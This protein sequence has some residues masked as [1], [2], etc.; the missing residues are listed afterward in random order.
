M[1]VLLLLLP[2]LGALAIYAW[3]GG[4]ARLFRGLGMAANVAALA[5]LYVLSRQWAPGAPVEFTAPWMPQLGLEFAIWLD[6]SALFWAW[7][8]LGIGLLVNWYAGHY[9]DPADAPRRFYGAMMLFMGSM[10]GVVLS[11]NLVLMFVFWEMTS[12]TSFLLIGHWSHKPGAAAGAKRALLLTGIGGLVLMTGVALLAIIFAQPGIEGPLNWDVLW[13]A[14]EQVLAHPLAR[15]AMIL[16]LTGAFTK[17]AQFPF[18][19]W[20]PGAMEAPTPVSAYLHAATMVKAGVYLVGRMY[21]AFNELALWLPLVAGTGVVT[22]MVGGWLALFCHD[23]KQLLAYS[24]VSQLGLLI[25]YYGFGHQPLGGGGELLT[26][27]LLLIAS[28]AF[29]KA[30]LFMLCG[31]VDHGAHTRD[32]RQLGG[33][34]RKMPVTA[35]LTALGCLSMAGGPFTLGFVAKK[36]FLEA[37]VHLANMQLLVANVLLVL[38]ITAS[39]F[40]MAYCLRL[41]ILVFLGKPRDD[42]HVAHAHEGSV[43]LLAAPTILVALCVAGGV[44][45][46]LIEEP[47]AR[48]VDPRFFNHDSHFI[49]GFFKKVDF[50]FWVSLFIYFV[51]GPIF[52]WAPERIPHVAALQSRVALFITFFDKLMDKWAPAFATWQ[53]GLLHSHSL[54]RNNLVILAFV[55][56]LLALVAP[57]GQATRVGLGWDGAATVFGLGVLGSALVSTAVVLLAGKTIYR[58]LALS[59]VGLAVGGLFLLYKAPD[60][61]I[62]Q[63]LVE[64]VLLLMFLLLLRKI[65]KPRLEPTRGWMRGATLAVSVL[66]GVVV[67]GLTLL[68]SSS[69]DRATP[70]PTAPQTLAS[71]FLEN[72]NYPAVAGDHSGRGDNAVNVILVDFR[73]LD[74]MGEVAV[75]VIAALGVASLL[76]MRRRRDRMDYASMPP[77]PTLPPSIGD[78]V[79]PAGPPNAIRVVAPLVAFLCLAYS[80]V[81]FLSGHNAPG[82]GFIGGLLA[83]IALLPFAIASNR[84]HHPY[85]VFRHTFIAIPVGIILAAGTGVVAMLLGAGFL[86]SGYT[87]L[88]V[89]LL[90]DVGLA[91]ALVFDLGVF[92]IVVGVT[93]TILKAFS[94]T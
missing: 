69:P 49:V 72:S 43:A 31:V 20:L 25:A 9:M 81:L 47:L 8:V 51:G 78:F 38:A 12:V 24:T 54:R 48:L 67:G 2:F 75:L 87:Y 83:A 41:V 90:G 66:V 1:L 18:H 19:F 50:L 36:L 59:I 71:F 33:L 65:G 26:L 61:A 53:R 23:I 14:R 60:L 92:L 29:F 57:L 13:G 40:T 91:S 58:I 16:M 76:R 21:P 6:G 32:W 55:F 79:V 45:V 10:L 84:P 7:L 62:T 93:W 39:V 4:G 17:S 11:R 27:D 44:F 15:V 46:P 35:A 5:V 74:T 88:P 30:A 80:A 70:T 34:W 94:K 37:G 52:F 77:A 85:P 22:M 28:H 68:A 56:G 89:P 63:V 82:G 64:L 3:P 42:K 73:A 86:R